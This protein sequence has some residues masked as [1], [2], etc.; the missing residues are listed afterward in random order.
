MRK[1]GGIKNK[2][3]GK[4]LPKDIHRL[5]RRG[6]IILFCVCTKLD[7][8]NEMKNINVGMKQ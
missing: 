4:I 5:F 8:V 7:D 1:K 3:A 6:L 2:K